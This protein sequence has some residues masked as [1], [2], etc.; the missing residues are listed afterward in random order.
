MSK[1]E[2]IYKQLKK[3]LNKKLK[4]VDLENIDFTKS[5]Q[6]DSIDILSLISEIEK[7]FKI[8]FSNNDF[9]KKNFSKLYYLAKIIEKKL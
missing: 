1:F 7:K 3:I 9:K 4:N 6:L 8:K 2:K 5:D